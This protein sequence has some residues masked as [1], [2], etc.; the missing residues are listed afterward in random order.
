MDDNTECPYDSTKNRYIFYEHTDKYMEYE[1][2]CPQENHYNQYEYKCKFQLSNDEK[3]QM[4]I[5]TI[6]KRFHCLLDKLFPLS[7]KHTNN[8]EYVDLEYLNYWLNYELHLKGSSICPKYFYQILKSMDNNDILSELSKNYGYIVNEEVKNMYSL[9]NLYYYY[10]EM[11]KDLNRDTPI[12]ETV[13]VYAN[14][15]V[16][17]YQKFEGHCSDTTTNFLYCFNCL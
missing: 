3:E 8:N 12:E 4:N 16:D 7:T 14:K 13:M 2:N 1:K 11:N 15:C 6:C 17:E 10:N 5:I 9:Y